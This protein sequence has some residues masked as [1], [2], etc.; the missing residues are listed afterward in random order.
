LHRCPP[1]A[2]QGSPVAPLRSSVRPCL[3][4]WIARVSLHLVAAGSVSA[5]VQARSSYCHLGAPFP[6]QWVSVGCRALTAN[7][8]GNVL[9]GYTAGRRDAAISNSFGYLRAFL[10]PRL[11]G[12]TPHCRTMGHQ[13]CIFGVWL[14]GLVPAE[15]CPT[16]WGGHDDPRSM[17]RAVRC[18]ALLIQSMGSLVGSPSNRMQWGNC[19]RV[20]G[21]AIL[22]GV[23]AAMT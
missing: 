12:G 2:Q 3:G 7:C 15:G 20:P 8:C 16:F 9:G 13:G 17:S 6:G 21:S 1:S 4:H 18:C 11:S 22:F 5:P 19:L 14:P 10:L 23:L